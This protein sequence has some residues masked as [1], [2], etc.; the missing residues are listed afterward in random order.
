VTDEFIIPMTLTPDLPTV[1]K[2]HHLFM[3]GDDQELG[4]YGENK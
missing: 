3:F 1:S 4:G 2:S